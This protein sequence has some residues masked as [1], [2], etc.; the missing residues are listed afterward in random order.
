MIQDDRGFSDGNFSKFSSKE[1]GSADKSK[2][3]DNSNSRGTPRSR[4]KSIAK[5]QSETSF[6]TRINSTRKPKC[7]CVKA[8]HRFKGSIKIETP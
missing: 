4:S 7:C 2:S 5:I 6:K 3:T 8:K 1:S